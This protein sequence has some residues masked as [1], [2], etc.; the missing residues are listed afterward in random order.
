MLSNIMWIWP[1][2]EVLHRRRGPSIGHVEHVDP[3]HDLEELA[4]QVERRAGT[5]R[6]HRS[7]CP[8]FFFRKAISS[9][10]VLAGMSR[11]TTSMLGSCQIFDTKVKSVRGLNGSLA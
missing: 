11:L 8:G 10:T 6:I 2:S 9:A 7:T 3:G 5:G 4:G 1:A